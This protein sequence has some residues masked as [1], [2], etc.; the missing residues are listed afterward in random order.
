MLLIKYIKIHIIKH[1]SW[2]FIILLSTFISLYIEYTK[3]HGM[4]NVKFIEY[5]QMS[6]KQ[7]PNVCGP[8]S[9]G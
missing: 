7:G 1:N 5:L 4:C 3:M 2:Y 9:A 6:A 8:L